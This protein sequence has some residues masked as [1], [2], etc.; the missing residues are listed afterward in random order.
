MFV[1][2]KDMKAEICLVSLSLYIRVVI[3]FLYNN[4]AK[5]NIIT[6]T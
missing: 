6:V 1:G 4:V 2:S 5:N 3:M